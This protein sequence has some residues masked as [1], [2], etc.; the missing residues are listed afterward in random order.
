MRPAAPPEGRKVLL[1]RIGWLWRSLSSGWRMVLRD[2]LRN[3]VRTI[4]GIF[5]AAMGAAV[6]VNAQMMLHSPYY[7]MDFQ[8]YWVNRADMEL[9]FMD[10]RGDDAL[11]E[12]ALLPGVDHAEPVLSVACT[13]RN[14]PYGKKGS[15]T[16][17]AAGARLTTPLD[18]QTRPVRVPA[19][20]LAMSREL[21]G[22]LRLKRGDRVRVEPVKGLRRPVE[23]PVN[24]I[25]EGYLGLTVYAEIDYL[26]RLIGEERALN[27]VQLALDG[28][29]ASRGALD[30]RLKEFPVLQATSSRA[31]MIRGF[32][33]SVLRNQWVVLVLMVVFAGIVFFGSVLNASLVSLAE[34]QR[35]VATLRCLGYGPWQIGTVLLRE[36]LI[37]TFF[38]TLLGMP[39]GYLLTVFISLSYNS[40][41]FRLPIVAPAS[42]W[43]WTLTLAAVFGLVAHLVVQRSIHRMAWL[44][45]LKAQE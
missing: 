6:L 34:R 9:T 28:D 5:A 33:E 43:T 23:V 10:E 41:M 2:L 45:A 11:R 42:T 25:T 37:A 14:G 27:G 17:L 12:A 15:I 38:G 22:L 7:L 44:D 8:F 21:A 24:E 18:L 40:E 16:G 29:L 13:F 32:E 1:E 30:R 4:A 39:L 3:R 26:S 35:E 20:G 31:D 19:S 36:S